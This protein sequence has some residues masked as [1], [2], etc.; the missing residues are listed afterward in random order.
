MFGMVV[1]QYIARLGNGMF[2]MELIARVND[3]MVTAYV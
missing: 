2:N 3:V 1:I